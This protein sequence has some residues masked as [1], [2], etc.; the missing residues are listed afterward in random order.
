MKLKTATLLGLIGSLLILIL[1][2]LYFFDSIKL[3]K[4]YSYIPSSLAWF[5]KATGSFFIF[6]FFYTLYNKQK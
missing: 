1:D 4:V 3:W 2:A 6:S 5:I